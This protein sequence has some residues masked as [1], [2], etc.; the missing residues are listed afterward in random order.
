MELVRLIVLFIQISWI[1]KETFDLLD[2]KVK[3][4]RENDTEGTKIFGKE[5]RKSL[6]KDR[7][8]RINK[9]SEEVEMKLQDRDIIGA[10]E[11]I[12]KWYQKYSGITME[13]LDE[14]LEKTRLNFKKLYASREKENEEKQM[15]I[16][17]M[18]CDFDSYDCC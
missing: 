10:F 4:L 5:V 12:R 3:A 2:K 8:A 14:D 16:V 1:S 15:N 7:R 18:N 6:R 13:P 9:V 17:D 11:I